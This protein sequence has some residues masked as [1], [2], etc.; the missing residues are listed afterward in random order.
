MNSQTRIIRILAGLVAGVGAAVI[1]MMISDALAHRIVPPPAGPD[2][3]A[4]NDPSGAATGTLIALIFGWLV[5]GL[6]GGWIAV[7]VSRVGWTAWAVAGAIILAA[8][9]LFTQIAHPLWSMAAGVAAPLAGAWL[10]QRLV[11]RGEPA[12]G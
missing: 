2:I 12:S 3:Y 5:A 11:R 7:R 8:I 6:V 10:A 4:A 1:L 9:Y